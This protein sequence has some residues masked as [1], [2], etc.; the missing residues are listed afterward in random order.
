MPCY[1]IKSEPM[2]LWDAKEAMGERHG[3]LPKRPRPGQ[4]H[5]QHPD[6]W[7]EEVA[8]E[9]ETILGADGG[10]GLCAVSWD[11]IATSQDVAR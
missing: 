9:T 2:T 10:D 5:S 7:P 1:K 3:F 4:G 6:L 8:R 11:L